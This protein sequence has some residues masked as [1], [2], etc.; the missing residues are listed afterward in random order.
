MEFHV[1]GSSSCN[2]KD[3]GLYFVYECLGSVSINQLCRPTDGRMVDYLGISG[4]LK[5]NDSPGDLH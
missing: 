5:K 3:P 4:Y 1:W 2:M